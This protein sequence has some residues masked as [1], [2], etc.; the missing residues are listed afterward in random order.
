MLYGRYITECNN[1][2]RN[3]NHSNIDL[4][5]M[6][7]NVLYD[8]LERFAPGFT[9]LLTLNPI[10]EEEGAF[11]ARGF[12]LSWNNPKTTIDMEL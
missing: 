6:F 3:A 10:P 12:I 5:N 9:V 4:S 7:Y 2:L 8:M 1:V 11:L